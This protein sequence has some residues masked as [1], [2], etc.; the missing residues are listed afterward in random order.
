[1]VEVDSLRHRRMVE[2]DRLRHRR[3]VDALE[4]SGGR[5]PVGHGD[6]QRPGKHR[7]LIK[8]PLRCGFK[9]RLNT[10]GTL[11]QAVTTHQSVLAIS[12]LDFVRDLPSYPRNP[13]SLR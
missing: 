11:W 7:T 6:R 12:S 10:D 3:M 8:P 9:G 4:T 1:M 13:R 5:R 2:S